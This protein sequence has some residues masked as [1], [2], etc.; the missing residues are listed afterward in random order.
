MSES[1]VFTAKILTNNK[2]I[3]K[4]ITYSF[5]IYLA[6]FVA[7]LPLIIRQRIQILCFHS[8]P[9]SLPS[10]TSHKY[11]IHLVSCI[12]LLPLQHTHIPLPWEQPQ[13]FEGKKITL[14]NG[15][16]L[17]ESWSEGS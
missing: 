3:E 14:C 2:G 13:N 8:L 16:S 11:I 7:K 12:F 15:L 9:Y 1:V 6:F 4:K 17:D 10:Y 5:N